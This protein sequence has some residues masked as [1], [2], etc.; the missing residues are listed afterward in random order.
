MS[1]TRLQNIYSSNTGRILYVA[2][3]DFDASDAISNRGNSPLRPF[4]TIQR[5]LLEAARFSYVPGNGGNND[6]FDQFTIMLEPGDHVIDI[7]AGKRVG[8]KTIGVLTGRTK[9]KEFEKAGANYVLKD[10][11]EIYKLLEECVK[12]Q[13]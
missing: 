3:D 7:Q 8:M 12:G 4:K 11:T 9:K 10:V 1:I 6:R 2:P 13:G 5:A